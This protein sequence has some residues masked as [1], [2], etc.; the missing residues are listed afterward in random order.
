MNN[1]WWSV[2]KQIL[3]DKFQDDLLTAGE[4][5][6]AKP[7]VMLSYVCIAGPP[8]GRCTYD[9]SPADP[10]KELCPDHLAERVF[11]FELDLE[12]ATKE[13][14]ALIQKLHRYREAG[15]ES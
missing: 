11:Q 7:S 8:M 15:R 12:R 14:A 5:A 9:V 3:Y 13:V 6:L 1:W 4:K 2:D 10:N